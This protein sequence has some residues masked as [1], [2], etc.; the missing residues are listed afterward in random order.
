[1]MNKIPH[2]YSKI[3]GKFFKADSKNLRKAK[4]H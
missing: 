3:L 2:I 1:M 4:L